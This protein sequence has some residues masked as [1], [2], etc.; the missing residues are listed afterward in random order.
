M[1]RWQRA[2][3]V[4]ENADSFNR[5]RKKKNNVKIDVVSFNW[6]QARGCEIELADPLLKLTDAVHSRNLQFY[7]ICGIFSDTGRCHQCSWWVHDNFFFFYFWKRIRFEEFLDFWVRNVSSLCV[8]WI[9]KS[10]SSPNKN[11]RFILIV[12]LYSPYFQWTSARISCDNQSFSIL[13][14]ED[15]K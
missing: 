11:P 3:I 9:Q 6:H 4:D 5:R 14:W 15:E 8:W 2:M 12:P 7:T 13:W 10:S 1:S